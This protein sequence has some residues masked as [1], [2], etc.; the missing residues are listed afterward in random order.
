MSYERRVRIVCPSC[1]AAYDLPEGALTPGRSVRCARCGTEWAP[2][3]AAEVKP[4]APPPPSPVAASAPPPEVAERPPEMRPDPVVAPRA[5]PMAEPAFEVGR[6]PSAWRGSVLP[7]LAWIASLAL[8]AAMI[9]SAVA[10]RGPIMAAWPPSERLY[11][12][13]GLAHGPATGGAATLPSRDAEAP[14]GAPQGK[15]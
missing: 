11:A 14:Q 6:R 1:A 13:L 12:A 10:W 9:A 4:A 7:A 8:V 15:P 2:A 5:M 3:A